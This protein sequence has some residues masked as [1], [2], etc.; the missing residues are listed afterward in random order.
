MSTIGI[1]A[2]T[3]M[4]AFLVETLVEFFFGTLF[5][6]VKVLTPYKW[7]LMYIAVAVGLVGSFT[8]RIDIIAIA[9]DAVRA[10][11]V[12]PVKWYGMII[13]GIAVGKGSNYI[14]Q[15]VSTFFPAKS[16]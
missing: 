11:P 16:G 8:Y 5:D 10:D 9:A 15:L 1:L 7:A 3:L 4:M 6:K 2:V 12:I 13:T 14:H